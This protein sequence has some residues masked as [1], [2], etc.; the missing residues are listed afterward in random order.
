MKRRMYIL[1]PTLK[2]T[3]TTFD[4]MLLARV[5]D[6]NI[7]VLARRG[8]DLEDLPEATVMQKS[9]LVHGAELGLFVGGMLGLLLG[10]LLL[11]FPP[12]GLPNSMG[13]ILV[14]GFFGAIFGAWASSFVAMS[15]PNTQ[16]AQFKQDIEQGKFLMM[17]DVPRDKVETVSKMIA[18]KHPVAINKGI[19]PTIPAFP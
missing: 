8:T 11:N 14:L 6:F 3:K 7:H 5:P 15:A 10:T 12:E 9:D 19:E 13:I 18:H 16:L 1:L 4:D 2:E 17:I